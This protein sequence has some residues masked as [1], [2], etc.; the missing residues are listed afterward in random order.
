MVLLRA[1]NRLAGSKLQQLARFVYC[2][3]AVHAHVRHE[4][5]RVENSRWHYDCD[6]VPIHVYRVHMSHDGLRF[7]RIGQRDSNV[8]IQFCDR[9]QRAL[10]GLAMRIKM[11]SV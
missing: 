7:I 1:G 3:H 8:C 10:W 4:R 9:V 11:D 5:R 6:R 2:A